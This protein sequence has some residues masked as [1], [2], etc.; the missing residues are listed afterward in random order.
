MH[1]SVV[2]GC[3]ELKRRLNKELNDCNQL[4]YQQWN[5]TKGYVA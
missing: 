5:I 3:K 2:S 1:N 4:I